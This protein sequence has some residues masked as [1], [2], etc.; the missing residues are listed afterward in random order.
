MDIACGGGYFLK[1]AEKGG[2]ETFGI[3]ISPVALE[4]ARTSSPRSKLACSA[5]ESLPFQDEFFDYLINLGSLEHFLDPEKGI[6]EMVRVLRKGGK[7]LL[8][9]PNSYFLLAVWNV[10]KKGS[11]GRETVQELDRTATQS[12]WRALIEEN[13]LQVEKIL[14]YNHKSKS[15]SLKYKILRPFIP[16]NFSYCF[17]FICRKPK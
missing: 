3:D 6:Q 1:E 12:E 13:G 4:I 17:I 8:L 7:A 14:K 15:A 9:L 2:V 16:L 11:T 10:F 5:G